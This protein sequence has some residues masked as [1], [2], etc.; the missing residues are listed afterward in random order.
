MEAV[1]SLFLSS[2]CCLSFV[3]V[4]K[5]GQDTNSIYLH[6]GIHCLDVVGRHLLMQPGHNLI[7]FGHPGIE[8]WLKG[9]ENRSNGG[10]QLLELVDCVELLTPYMDAWRG[11]CFLPHHLSLFYTDR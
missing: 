8:L 9:G 10:S 11:V 4:E 1:Q 2:E 7:G 5:S 3:G 6:L